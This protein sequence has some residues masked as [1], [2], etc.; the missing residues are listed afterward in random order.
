MQMIKKIS[1]AIGA[2]LALSTHTLLSAEVNHREKEPSA[3]IILMTKDFAEYSLKYPHQ[4]GSP[5]SLYV[6]APAL[7]GHTS[8]TKTFAWQYMGQLPDRIACLEAGAMLSKFSYA[9]DSAASSRPHRL[10]GQPFGCL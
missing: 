4:E 9:G 2:L 10:S 8:S 3:G 6:I 7:Q 5:Y 1:L